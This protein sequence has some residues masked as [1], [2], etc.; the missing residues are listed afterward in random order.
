MFIRHKKNKSGSISIQIID[1]SN[2]KYKVLKT[3]GSSHD[4]TEIELL[5]Q[6][7]QKQI[8]LIKRQNVLPF[9]EQQ[10]LEFADS[11]VNFIQTLQLIGPEL[12]LGKL[13]DEIGFNKI[14]DHLFRDLVIT[15]LVYPVSKLK[16]V[17]YLFKYKGINLSVY[18]I[19]RYLDKLHSHQID[20]IKQISL[21]HTLE[22]FNNKLAILFYDVTTLYFEAKE[23]D[24]FRKN[25]FSKDGKHSQPQIVLGLLVSEGG[26]PLDYD[27]F[28]GDKYEGDTLIP[29]IEHFANKHK[30]EELIVVADAGLL[31]K[32]NINGLVN[33]QYQFILG[34]RIKNEN[35][36]IINKILALKLGDGESQIIKREDGSSLIMSY[37]KSRA[38]NDQRNRKKGLEALEK[39]VK[40]GKLTKKNINNKGYNKYLKIEGKTTISIDYEKYKNDIVW[41]GLKGYITNTKLSKDEVI[42][43]YHNLW[44]VEKTF[45]ISKSD[46]EIRPIY[47]QLK[48]RIESHIC[49]AFAACKIY[50]ELERQLKLKQSKL[51]PEKAIDIIKTIYK[52]SF[53]TPY[54]TKVYQRLIIKNEEQKEI[55]KLFN[56][57][58]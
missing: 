12:L 49:I 58:S 42:K 33:K 44:N 8:L 29:V 27:V 48:R 25:G 53:E 3:I 20:I 21:K 57:E 50:K 2:G 26:Y 40:S 13:F 32:K 22:L 46:L 39:K 38:I 10:E 35:Q 54:S 16:T 15:R 28:E 11:F 34:A 37:K 31:S 19:Y 14:E 43:Q 55:I 1:K 41:D 6:K 47:H 7:A 5:I 30:P 45:R 4:S 51:S 17:D 23:E 9:N 56:L 18:S 36:K 24:D 52:V